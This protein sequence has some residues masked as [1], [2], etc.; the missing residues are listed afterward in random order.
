MLHACSVKGVIGILMRFYDY[1]DG[2]SSVVYWNAVPCYS[3]GTA[4]HH[5]QAVLDCC[6]PW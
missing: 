1:V 6:A 5:S 2:I 4:L 3:G